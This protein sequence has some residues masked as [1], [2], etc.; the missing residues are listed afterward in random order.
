MLNPLTLAIV[1][2]ISNLLPIICGLYWY[3]HVKKEFKLFLYF[4]M[5]AFI[6]SISVMLFWFRGINNLF[7]M[8]FYTV[9]EFIFIV[10]VL[11]QWQNKIKPKMLLLITYI[12]FF[13]IWLIAKIFIENTTNFDH[14]SSSLSSAIIT[15]IS[16]YTLLGLVKD[17][18]KPIENAVFLIVS[19]FLIYFSGNL[20]LF[21]LSSTVIPAS[22]VIHNGLAIVADLFYAGGFLALRHL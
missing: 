6:F 20:V 17:W 10:Y 14:I 5:I 3:T 2:I 16:A 12:P 7:I 1:A 8:H 11:S 22:W 4:L 21:A 15:V 19:G 9:F 13:I 18:G